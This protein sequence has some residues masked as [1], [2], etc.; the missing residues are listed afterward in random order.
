MPISPI[1]FTLGVE[2][3]H[4]I[5]E[6][7]SREL[8]SLAQP[9]I[10]R[11]QEQAGDSV[12]A[13]L[14][15][16]QVETASSVCSTLDEVRQELSSSRG[17]LRAAAEEFGCAIVS[18]ATH[19]FSDWKEQEFASD[20]R[21]QTIH[22]NFQQLAREQLLYGCH[23]HVGLPDIGSGIE[24]LNRVRPWL[25][26]LLALSAS[27]PFWMGEDTGYAS[28]RTPVYGR[29]PTAGPPH[30][31]ADREEYDRLV[32]AMR[33]T[34]SIEDASKI[35]WDA[36]LPYRLPTI[37]FRVMDVCTLLDEAVMVAGLARALVH[38][39]YEHA[40]Q[41]T[42]YPQTR[43]ELLRAAHWRAARYGL[44]GELIDPTTETA[45]PA[46]AL[47]EKLLDLV[48]PSLEEAGDWSE[49][50]GLLHRTLEE[51]NSAER[52]RR[53]Y[54]RTGRIEGVVDALMEETARSTASLGE[55]PY[56]QTTYTDL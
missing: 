36:R 11:A 28:Y 30:L 1:E 22:R 27:S 42:S 21:Y 52:Q 23:V 49:V 38:T 44:E 24:V 3:E 12:H 29:W 6:I 15:L 33:V 5:V 7:T 17:V 54:Q 9:I 13:E 53:A 39:C 14:R 10:S 46:R 32:E 25:A 47:L 48:R 37:E 16:S 8:A 45:V 34:G 55:L 19:P 56:V 41:E 51:G 4:Q 50:S 26:S 20:E 31:F 35:Y 40:Q 2:E 43:Q 18:A